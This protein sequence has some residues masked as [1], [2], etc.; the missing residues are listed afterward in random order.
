MIKF[1]PRKRKCKVCKT[2]YMA[3]RPMQNVCN[4]YCANKHAIQNREKAEK[5]AAKRERAQIKAAKEAIKPRGR[6]MAEAQAAFNAWIRARDAG[7]V[8]IS[9]D[10]T[11]SDDGLMTGSRIDAGHYRSTGACPELRFEPLNC[12]AQCVKCNRNLSGNAVEYRIRLV[13]RIGADKVEWLEGN[14]PAKK[15]TIEQLQDIKK[16]YRQKTRELKRKGEAA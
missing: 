9:C 4:G 14:H 3:Q 6:H 11:M 16:H 10:A 15:Y 13:K 1:R 2:E 5:D 8:C 12:H 7:R